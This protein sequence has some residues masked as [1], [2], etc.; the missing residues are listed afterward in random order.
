MT[1]EQ[2]ESYI[3]DNIKKSTLN[4]TKDSL[5]K[6]I[7]TFGNTS[8]LKDVIRK[9]INKEEITVCTFGGSIT[10][11]ASHHLP[12]KEGLEC[13]F[14][15]K[16]YIDVICDFLEEMFGCKTVRINA[17]IGATDSV[18]ATHRIK[19][20]VLKYNP[21]LVINEWCCNDGAQF[22]YKQATYESVVRKL[23]QSGCA[24]ILVSFGEKDGTSSQSVHEPVSRHYNVPHLSYRDAFISLD[25]YK[26]LSNDRVHPNTVG[27]AI[28]GLL[29][30]YYIGKVY[31][32]ES[33]SEP[34]PVLPLPYNEDALSYEGADVYTIDDIY[35]GKY[36]GIKI[37]QL[38]S[39]TKDSEQKEFAYRK[40]YGYSA[41]CTD[42]PQPMIVEID[43]LKTLF[44]LM[45]RSNQYTG[46]KFYIEI[47]G[48]TVKKDTFTCQHG[49]DNR[50]T[51][52]SYHW[53]SERAVKFDTPQRVTLKIYPD[54]TNKE[55]PVKLFALLIS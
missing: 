54:T 51:E 8:G 6:G 1:K 49:S 38:G 2:F 50:Q 46:A 21:D 17:G 39:F 41:Y 32:E 14:E 36:E 28:A 19:E 33:E 4:I 34:D 31:L 24:L 20:D 10:R 26:Y 53:A 25:E 7:Y 55:K 35:N 5:D 43:S 9:A 23:L 40:Y 48:E 45:Y 16:K 29:I 52:F 47:N 18:F 12:P 15:P 42:T 30:N 3:N 37:I 11:G 22:I 44:F 27:H 13:N